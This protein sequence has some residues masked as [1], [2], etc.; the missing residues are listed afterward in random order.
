[1]TEIDF[2]FCTEAGLPA[3]CLVGRVEPG[4]PQAPRA[5]GLARD[6]LWVQGRCFSL[7]GGVFFFCGDSRRT[8]LEDAA[9]RAAYLDEYC[10]NL[11]KTNG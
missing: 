7:A 5:R 6:P 10:A 4:V 11:Q 8:R 2:E 3:G 9:L 1:M